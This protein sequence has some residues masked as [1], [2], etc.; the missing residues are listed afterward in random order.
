[1]LVYLGLTPIMPE[2]V[3]LGIPAAVWSG[4]VTLAISIWG[5]WLYW[6]TEHDRRQNR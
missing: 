1:V 4:G 2:P 3:I 6:R 5:I